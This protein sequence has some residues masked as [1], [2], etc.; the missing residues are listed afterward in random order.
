MIIPLI[1][2]LLGLAGMAILIGRRLPVARLIP[3]EHFYS[4]LNAT[5]PFFE[6]YRRMVVSPALQFWK[7]SVYPLILKEVEKAVSYSRL[8]MVRAERHLL[9]FRDYVRGKRIVHIHG[10][11]KIYWKQVNDYKNDNPGSAGD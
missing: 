8:G 9:N 10:I 7:V 5:T 2:I 4:A 6:D 11:R 3:E 1:L